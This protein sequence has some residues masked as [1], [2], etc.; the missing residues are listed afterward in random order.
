MGIAE[1]YAGSD[2]MNNPNPFAEGNGKELARKVD[3]IA[4]KYCTD[5]NSVLHLLYKQVEQV[6]GRELDK[7]KKK[8]AMELLWGEKI[9]TFTLLKSD[10][11]LFSVALDICEQ[12]LQK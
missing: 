9:T 7:E 1:K 4:D 12:L 10:E 2:I 11:D 8:L 3:R 6:T 5:A